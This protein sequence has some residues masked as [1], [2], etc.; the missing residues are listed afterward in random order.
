MI[1]KSLK[2]SKLKGKMI[3]IPECICNQCNWS[4]TPRTPYPRNCP[5]CQSRKW[6]KPKK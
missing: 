1:K 4:W 3:Y 5:D 2:R 6:D